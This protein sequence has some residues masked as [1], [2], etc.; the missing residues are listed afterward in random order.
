MEKL[1]VNQAIERGIKY[2]APA[3]VFETDGKGHVFNIEE[4]IEEMKGCTDLVF[5]EKLSGV[6]S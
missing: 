4:D 3:Y 5:C 1:T 2:A 6:I